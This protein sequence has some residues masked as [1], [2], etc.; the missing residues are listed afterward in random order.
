[1]GNLLVVETMQTLFILYIIGKSYAAISVH[2][3]DLFGLEVVL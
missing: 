2:F 3:R 1:L